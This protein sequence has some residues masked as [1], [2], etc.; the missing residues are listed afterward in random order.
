MKSGWTPERTSS[1]ENKAGRIITVDGDGAMAAGCLFIEK[2]YNRTF[3]VFH[4]FGS[5]SATARHQVLTGV[6]WKAVRDLVLGE[7]L[8]H[9]PGRIAH[10]NKGYLSWP[11]SRVAD[12]NAGPF[13]RSSSLIYRNEL[14]RLFM[15]RLLR[16]SA[17]RCAR[18]GRKKAK[19]NRVII[20]RGG[21]KQGAKNR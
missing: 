15:A 19:R 7:T 1:T 21:R 13:R 9:M 18:D 20:C 3:R 14:L 4:P 12:W 10:S 11:T 8:L 2:K 5:F 16:C 17:F 6:G